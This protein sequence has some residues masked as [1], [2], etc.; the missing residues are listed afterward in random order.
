MLPGVGLGSSAASAA[1]VA[2]GLNVL[3]NLEMD[4]KDL[5]R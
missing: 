1:A 3:F 2:F 4:R 5:T